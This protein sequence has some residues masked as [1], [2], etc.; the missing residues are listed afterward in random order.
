MSA[1]AKD[2]TDLHNPA[3]IANNQ[4][5]VGAVYELPDGQLYST[6]AFPGEA[7][8]GATCVSAKP[9]LAIDAIP[10]GARFRALWHTHGAPGN[11]GWE[12]FGRGDL[13]M[14]YQYSMAE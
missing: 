7:C 8:S 1:V 12:K 2:A 9:Q 10:D 14:N 6:P 5:Y 4:E 13:I 3:S 11:P